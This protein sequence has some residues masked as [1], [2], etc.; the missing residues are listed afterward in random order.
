MTAEGGIEVRL[1]MEKDSGVES[2]TMVVASL[3]TA[4]SMQRELKALGVGLHITEP[5][6]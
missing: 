4:R 5:E 2:W 6:R 3:E 1:E